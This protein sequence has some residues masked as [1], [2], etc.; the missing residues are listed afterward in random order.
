MKP[1]GM[2]PKLP[3]PSLVHN[4][5]RLLPGSAFN[6]CYPGRAMSLVEATATP[7][8]RLGAPLSPDTLLI[9]HSW[10]I[11]CSSQSLISVSC[12]TTVSGPTNTVHGRGNV[13]AVSDPNFRQTMIS[14]PASI[15]RGRG[16]SSSD[17][18][19]LDSRPDNLFC[20]IEVVWKAHHALPH[21]TPHHRVRRPKILTVLVPTRYLLART[22]FV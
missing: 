13:V 19:D 7:S 18:L 9:Q 15:T 4:T 16:S 21:Y 3:D 20:T 14:G 12:P 11:G 6:R 8:W 17:L 22:S 5:K 1:H 10:M 2:Y